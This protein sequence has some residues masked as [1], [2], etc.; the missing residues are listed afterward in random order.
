MS[1]I[2]INK[3]LKILQNAWI[4]YVGYV[5]GRVYKKLFHVKCLVAQR[6]IVSRQRS[7]S[8][9]RVEEEACLIVSPTKYVSYE[10]HDDINRASSRIFDSN[11]ND[12]EYSV[13]ASAVVTQ[14]IHIHL[15]TTALWS[16]NKLLG[17]LQ[18]HMCK[19]VC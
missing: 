3:R 16:E 6:N 11:Q 10:V 9:L 2:S 1:Y 5:G 19:I 4:L 7:A 18:H 17:R 8:E 12:R 15:E 13:Y 14:F